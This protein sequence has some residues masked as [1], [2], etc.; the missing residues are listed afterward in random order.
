MYHSIINSDQ[1]NNYGLG[2]CYNLFDIKRG[3]KIDVDYS[4]SIPMNIAGTKVLFNSISP[5]EQEL[6]YYTKIHLPSKL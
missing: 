5:R 4:I 1:V 2:F 6:L 3:L